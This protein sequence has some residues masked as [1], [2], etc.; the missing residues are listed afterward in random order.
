MFKRF[1]GKKE[2]RGEKYRICFWL[3]RFKFVRFLILKIKLIK[4]K[5]KLEF[6]KSIRGGQIWILVEFTAPNLQ[7][8]TF[9][10]WAGILGVVLL[11]GVLLEFGDKRVKAV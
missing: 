5:S 11:G 10:L 4:V 7:K 1:K 2:G 8:T 3:E 9:I 6:Q